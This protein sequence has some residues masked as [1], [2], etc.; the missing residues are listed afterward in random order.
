MIILCLRLTSAL[1]ERQDV[2]IDWARTHTVGRFSSKQENSH[3]LRCQLGPFLSGA[4]SSYP[5]STE[6]TKQEVWDIMS[7]DM[8]NS[9]LFWVNKTV[10]VH[11]LHEMDCLMLFPHWCW[12]RLD[13]INNNIS[14]TSGVQGSMLQSEEGTSAA[15]VKLLEKQYITGASSR[16]WQMRRRSCI[17]G[18]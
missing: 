18:C 16:N 10:C 17:S 14:P 7:G 5:Q 6:S 13:G 8:R 12:S 3:K 15:L 4:I 2:D 11:R 1:P 9:T